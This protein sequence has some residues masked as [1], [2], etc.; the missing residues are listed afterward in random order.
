MKQDFYYMPNGLT[1]KIHNKFQKAKLG[2]NEKMTSNKSHRIF[3][4]SA[5]S[6][7]SNML[8]NRGRYFYDV[9]TTFLPYRKDNV[10]PVCVRK[11]HSKIGVYYTVEPAMSIHHCNTR[12]VA[13]QGKWLLMGGSFVYKMS[14]WVMTKWPPIGGWLLIRVAVHSRFYCICD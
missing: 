11:V 9:G 2:K 6:I 10:V 5:W 12:K 14:Y 4:N 1:Y 7:A 8:Y 13:F 3:L